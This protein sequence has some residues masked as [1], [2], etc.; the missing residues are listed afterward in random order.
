MDQNVP[1]DA[2]PTPFVNPWDMAKKNFLGGG[3]D[4]PPPGGLPR[5]DFISQNDPPYALIQDPASIRTLRVI[6]IKNKVFF[7]NQRLK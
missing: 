2:P 1:R 6:M 7:E 3:G 4:P 5:Y